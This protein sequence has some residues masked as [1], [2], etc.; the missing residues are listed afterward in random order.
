M[1]ITYTHKGWI[2]GVVPVYLG[3]LESG[4]P[5]VEVRRWV[6]EWW[7]DLWAAMFDLFTMV[8]CAV[9]PWFEPMFPIVETG[10]LTPPI[11]I[12]HPEADR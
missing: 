10:E 9:N 11:V 8:A 7:F 2:F 5:N 3:N 6:P 12:D 1:K 4:A